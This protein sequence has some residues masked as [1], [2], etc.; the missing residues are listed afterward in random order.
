MAIKLK[1][2][3]WSDLEALVPN[4]KFIRTTEI[5]HTKRDVYDASSS[6]SRGAASKALRSHAL[7]IVWTHYW[8]FFN[9]S[10][11]TGTRD[12]LRQDS[13]IMQYV[14]E[15]FKDKWCEENQSIK[16][17][18]KQNFALLGKYDQILEI[19]IL[20]SMSQNFAVNNIHLNHSQKKVH[21]SSSASSLKSQMQSKN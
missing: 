9:A 15:K 17:F 2:T 18:Q 16:P 7:H 20:C 19:P 1:K 12:F 21:Q 6:S 10:Q 14:T 11:G 13:Y 3:E 4:K 8:L 5:N